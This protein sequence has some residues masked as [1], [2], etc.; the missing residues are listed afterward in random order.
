MVRYPHYHRD[1]RRAM[2]ALFAPLDPK[3]GAEIGVWNGRTSRSL[4]KKFPELRLYM[5]DRWTP[6]PEGD[7]WLASGD[8]FALRLQEEHDE[9]YRCA[10]NA[11]SDFGLRAV[12]RKMSSIAAAT[13]ILDGDLDFVFIDGDHSFDGTRADIDAWYDKVRCGGII[14]GHDYGEGEELGYGVER[15]VRLSFDD[16]DVLPETF[17]WYA[18]KP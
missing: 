10:I 8:R 13:T 14:S 11:T 6:P 2:H 3:R 12:I 7:S 16:F 4:L 5:V 9:A 15:A 17:I 1:K 18:R